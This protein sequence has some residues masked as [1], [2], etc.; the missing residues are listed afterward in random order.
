MKNLPERILRKI[1]TNLAGHLF[2][3]LPQMMRRA[4]TVSIAS[5]LT[6]GTTSAANS[7]RSSYTT[8]TRHTLPSRDPCGTCVA[9]MRAAC[10]YDLVSLLAVPEMRVAGAPLQGAS[11]RECSW[12][13]CPSVLWRCAGVQ[14][15]PPSKRAMPCQT[16]S[17]SAACATRRCP[18][19]PPPADRK[20]SSADARARPRARDGGGGQRRQ[21][22]TLVALTRTCGA[23]KTS[24]AVSL[25][26]SIS[27]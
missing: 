20:Q 7:A 14:V 15:P 24:R 11:P 26:I 17:S 25:R 13:V 8:L 12:P 21:D 5:A 4:V 18:P 16:S 1:A 22:G 19:A 23:A 9:G 3:E 2:C 27:L 6:L 10:F